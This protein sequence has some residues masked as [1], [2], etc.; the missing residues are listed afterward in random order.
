MKQVTIQNGNI[1]LVVLDYGATLQKLMLKNSDGSFTNVVVGYEY[2]SQYLDDEKFLGACIGRYAGRI[3]KE[4]VLDRETYPLYNEN[5]IHLH[6]GKKG[7][8][9]KY[10]KFEKVHKGEE[11]YVKLSYLSPHLEEGYPGNL[12]TTVTYVLKQ[13]TVRIIHEATTD[14]TTVVNLTNHSYFRLDNENSVSDY[15]LKLNC[16][17]YLETKSNLLPTGRVLAT[18]DSHFDFSTAK[19][20]AKVNFDTPFVIDAKSTVAAECSSQKSGITLEV[21][22]NQPSMVVYT[23]QDFAAICFE[24]QNVPDAP[25]HS[26][27]PNCILRPKERYRNISEFRFSKN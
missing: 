18:K 6:G 17:Q 27:F 5:G 3:A 9:K 8:G 11:P 24:T 13:N 4:F 19:P 10:W 25:N 22:T 23:P 12:K 20:I 15:C 21:A 1:I 2:P 16:P 26:H 14:R 7:F